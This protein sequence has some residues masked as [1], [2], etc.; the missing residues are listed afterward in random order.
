MDYV[1]RFHADLFGP[2]DSF[3]PDFGAFDGADVEVAEKSIMC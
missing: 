3:I 1:N 2:E